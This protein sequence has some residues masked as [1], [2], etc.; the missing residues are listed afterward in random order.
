MQV[1]RL[2]RLTVRCV[3]V[4]QTEM[5]TELWSESEN[6]TKS[7]NESESED[8]REGERGRA[9]L[10]VIPP[11]IQNPVHRIHCRTLRPGSPRLAGHT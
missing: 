10:S 7:E 2:P 5:G 9:T 3:C 8:E 11:A 4:C 1:Y 6:E